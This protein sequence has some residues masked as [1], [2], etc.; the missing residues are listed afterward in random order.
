MTLCAIQFTLARCYD[1]T[2]NFHK[3]LCTDQ[4]IEAMTHLLSQLT[5][6]INSKTEFSSLRLPQMNI[7]VQKQTMWLQPYPFLCNHTCLFKWSIGWGAITPC[8]SIGISACDCRNFRISGILR[9][10]DNE[11]CPTNLCPYVFVFPFC[12]TSFR[13]EF[14]FPADCGGSLHFSVDRLIKIWW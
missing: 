9:N 12:E 2:V 11:L 5:I 1:N 7:Q 10:V 4:D 8:L 3:Q 6:V 13:D 14:V